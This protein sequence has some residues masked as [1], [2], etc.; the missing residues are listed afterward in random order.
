MSVP[1]GQVQIYGDWLDGKIPGADPVRQDLLK[2]G[3]SEV[4]SYLNAIYATSAAP[5]QSEYNI[6][7]S[8]SVSYTPNNWNVSLCVGSSCL[9]YDSSSGFTTKN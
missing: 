7:D 1:D 3:N 5:N 8:I 2:Q 4:I 6:P 9:K